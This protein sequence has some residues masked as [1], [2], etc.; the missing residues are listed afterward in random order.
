[1]KLISRIVLLCLLFSVRAQA[2]WLPTANLTIFSEDG[3]KF[4][5]I[6]NGE[7]M[8]D[9]AQ[10]NIRIEELPQPYYNAR[11]IFEDKT[12]K[13][14]SKNNLMLT[15]AN[16]VPQDVTYKIKKDKSGKQLLRFYSFIPAEQNMVR[17]TNAT[18]YRFGAPAQPIF[19]PGIQANVN[20]PLGNF[21][22][23]STQQGTNI[24]VNVPGVN[25]N[26]NGNGGAPRGRAQQGGNGNYNNGYNNNGGY[27]QGN[28]GGY[29]NGNYNQ[30]NNGYNQG[31][32]NG[33]N[34]GNNGYN[35]GYN[36]GGYQQGQ[37][38][39][40]DPNQPCA[41]P[42]LQRDFDEARALIA[43]EGFDDTRL[44]TAKQVMAQ[45]CLNVSQIIVLCKL[46]SFEDTKLE[47]A[48]FAYPYCSEPRNYFKVNSV[49]NFDASKQELNS[50]MNSMR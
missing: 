16:G 31:Y 37:A 44:N 19:G 49:F 34:Q 7:R 48:K 21:N 50:Y 46:F 9:E 17:P 24:N 35:Q 23:G 15:D 12:Q 5:L 47:F 40:F 25:V 3:Y 33:Y 22:Y 42:M 11:I 20:T 38:Y 28:Q 1:M 41:T 29:N 39:H 6:L 13:P 36:N 30:G 26:V 45:N 14:I 32:N 2:Q 43:K 8:N 18:V 27:N 10:T 4:F